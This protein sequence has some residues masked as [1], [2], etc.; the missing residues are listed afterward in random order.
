MT[1]VVIT[2]SAHADLRVHGAGGDSRGGLLFGVV[3][4]LG[5]IRV[6][7]AHPAGSEDSHQ[8]R[9]VGVW[10]T[11]PWTGGRRPVPTA[12]HLD[13]WASMPTPARPSVAVVAVLPGSP[14]PDGWANPKAVAWVAGKPGSVA[15]AIENAALRFD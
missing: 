1:T 14:T 11:A 2:R 13:D 9:T 15:T 7:E 5:E 6:L 10:F 12:E 8:G 3:D 4:E